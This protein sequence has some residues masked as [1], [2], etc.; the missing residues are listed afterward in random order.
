[1]FSHKHEVEMSRK[2]RENH[3]L[4]GFEAEELIKIDND[5]R[6]EDISQYIYPDDKIINDVGVRGIYLGNYLRWDPTAQHQLMIKK[7]GYKS[8]GLSRTFDTYDH[9]DC[10]N[11][12]NIHD[13]LKLCKE[14]IQKLLIMY[15]EKLDTKG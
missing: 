12:M 11:Y 2:Y 5:I 1:M 14:G 9:V 7:Y 6:E 3:D 15:V 8:C 13:Y 10:Y 4:F